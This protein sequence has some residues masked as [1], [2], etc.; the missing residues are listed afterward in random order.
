MF[1]SN[2]LKTSARVIKASPKKTLPTKAAL[3]L[4]NEAL[5]RIKEIMSERPEAEGLKIGVKQRGC[6]GLTYTLEYASK[7]EKFDEEVIQDGVK[8]WIDAKAQ[9]TLLGTEMDY[10][11]NRITSEFVFRNPNVK[12]TC[13]C[14]E[15]FTV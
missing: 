9:L 13:G 8:I 11:N 6:N 5:N 12:N 7:K 1:I 15:S 4:T 3:T 10:I 14:G 2:L